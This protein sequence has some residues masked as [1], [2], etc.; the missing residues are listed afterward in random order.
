MHST[1]TAGPKE[2]RCRAFGLSICLPA[3][4]N[5]MTVAQFFMIP[6]LARVSN[7]TGLLP[8]DS[9]WPVQVLSDRGQVGCPFL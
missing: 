3:T 1:L 5:A 8:I 9:F 6:V 7:L 2:G 4:G